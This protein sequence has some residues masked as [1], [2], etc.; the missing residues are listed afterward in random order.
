M[1]HEP[2][3]L[4]LYLLLF[5]GVPSVSDRWRTVASFLHAMRNRS[6]VAGPH[7]VRVR[8]KAVG[9]CG[10]DVHYLKVKK[11]SGEILPRP[12]FFVRGSP[13]LND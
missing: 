12:Q 13:I 10:S 7:D 8:M 6:G 4:D 5:R 2:V 3:F 11:E 9:I 1:P